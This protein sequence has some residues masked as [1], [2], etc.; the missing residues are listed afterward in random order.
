MSKRGPID[1]IHLKYIDD[2]SLAEAIN[3]REKL[4]D[5][6]DPNPQRPF[7]FHDRT[8]HVLPPGACLLQEQLLSLQ[9][10][11]KDNQME[12]NQKKC[13]VMIFNPHKK[14]D[15]TPKLTLSG[16][17]SEYLEVVEN[18]HLLGVKL[19]S[20]LRWSDN[21]NYICQKGFSRLWMIRRLKG[22]GAN[23]AEL[24][25]IYQK[26]VR[27][28]LE[29]AVP[30][31]QPM[32]TKQERRQIERIQRC[33][34]HI[35]LGQE[36]ESY[37]NALEILQSE[38]LEERRE[39]ICKNFANKSVRHL[40]YKSWFNPKIKVAESKNTRQKQNQGN[41]KFHPVVFR[42]ERYKKSPLPYLTEL[43]N[44]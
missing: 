19:Q 16:E 5:N 36:Y 29:L 8:N 20:D 4:V 21:C 41:K 27:S 30:V 9:K 15:V 1:K 22:L 33:A 23:Q 12:I 26:Q 14:Y 17:G 39:K 34:F 11:C 7:T 24:L 2:L 32:I 42:T 10:Y 18:I 31:W 35:I 40:K 13:K 44:S 28:I 38:S 37:N 6:P 3:L 43:L 25:D